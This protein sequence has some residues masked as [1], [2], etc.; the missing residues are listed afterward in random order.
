MNYDD[1]LKAH[2]KYGTNSENIIAYKGYGKI[3]ENV[4]IAP[5][6]GHNMFDNYNFKVEQVGERVFNLSK[7]NVSFS[8]IELKQIGAPAIIDYI[9]SLGVTKCKNLLFLGSVGS[10]DNNINIGDIVIPKYSICGDGTSRYLNKNLEDELFKKEYPSKDLTDKIIDILNK[11]SINYHYVPNFSVDSIFLQFYHLDKILDAGAKVIEMETASIFKCKDILNI[12]IS[13][14]FS[15]SDS[16]IKNKSLYSGRTDEEKANNKKTRYEVI[17]NIIIDLFK[18]E[19]SN[20][21]I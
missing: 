19:S 12:N 20:D 16:T 11:K 4:I 2:L 17:P 15:V 18:K 7:D 1:L 10:L 9:L 6:W 13:A 3:L 21:N 14:L 5:W 8:F